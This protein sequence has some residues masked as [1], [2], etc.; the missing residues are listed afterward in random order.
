MSDN[1]LKKQFQQKDVQ[2]LRNLVQGK[3][4]E[5]VGQS[6]G[7]SKATID[8]KEGDVWVSDR[9]WETLS[10]IITYLIH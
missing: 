1:V 7:Y 2:R 4:G 10:D 5:K 6:V 9:D 8:H 3:Y